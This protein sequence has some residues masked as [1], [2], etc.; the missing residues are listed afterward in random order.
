[1]ASVNLTFEK[2]KWIRKCYWKTENVTE[3]QRRWLNEFGTPQMVSHRITTT[4][5][6]FDP[7]LF[8]WKMDR[9]KGKGEVSTKITRP[10]IV[11]LFPVG[12]SKE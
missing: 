7:C 6:K 4:S 2:R 12:C 11:T 3:V 8:S 10:N 9:T 5:E 1:M